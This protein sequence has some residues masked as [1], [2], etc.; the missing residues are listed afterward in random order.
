MQ[1]SGSFVGSDFKVF[2][3]IAPFILI[4]F[5]GEVDANGNLLGPAEQRSYKNL[6]DLFI[7]LAEF[8]TLLYVTTIRDLDAWQQR[9]SRLVS[10]IIYC[11]SQWKA[12]PV[13]TDP[14]S[15]HSD[16]EADPGNFP[17]VVC[18][19]AAIKAGT[20]AEAVAEAA[21]AALSKIEQRSTKPSNPLK[22]PR[23]A[24]GNR[25]RNKT[26]GKERFSTGPF[27]VH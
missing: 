3:Q 12:G 27:T 24:A 1:W 9:C 6:R 19:S 14:G 26:Q 5:L 4:H 10:R 20:S 2:L 17:Q 25:A 22:R 23:R 16:R 7:R 15:A 18:V 13:A 11:F 8:N 21:T